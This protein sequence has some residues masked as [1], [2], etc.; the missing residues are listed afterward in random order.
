MTTNDRLFTKYKM[1]NAIYCDIHRMPQT[2]SIFL[3]FENSFFLNKIIY[4]YLPKNN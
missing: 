3:R 4:N 2:Y 1:L